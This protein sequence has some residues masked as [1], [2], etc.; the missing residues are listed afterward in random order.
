M[1][2]FF[3]KLTELLDKDTPDWRD[4]S[5]VLLDGA[6]YH[7]GD[8]TREVLRKLQ[9]PVIYSGPY[10]YSAAPIELLFAGLKIGKLVEI[11]EQTGKK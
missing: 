11:G 7:T 6:K 10:S 4:N 2:L 1:A 3:M 9:I 5:V 8:D